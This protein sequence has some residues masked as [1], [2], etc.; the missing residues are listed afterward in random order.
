MA[1]GRP[2]IS[3]SRIATGDIAQHTF[4]VVRRGFDSDEVRSYLQSVARSL[5]A[6][7]AREEELRASLAEAEERA[8]HPVVDEATLTASLGQHSAQILRHA[9]EEAA[10][11]VV[12]AQEGAALLLRET[13]SQVDEL[14]ER[15]ETSAA[16]R[17]VEVELLVA[18]AE[19]EARVES[20][21]IVAEAI[22]AGEAIITR[23]K[24]E[25]RALL[26]QVQEA[27]RRVLAD[28][29]G[30][31]RGLGIQ[32]EQLR[33]ARDEMAASV[34]GVR[35]RVDGILAHLDRTD[36]DARAAAQGVA[37]QF[38]LGTA[39][40]PHDQDEAGEVRGEVPPT[41]PTPAVGGEAGDDGTAPSV[42][43]L[44][45]RI[46]AGTAAA[47]EA[48]AQEATVATEPPAVAPAKEAAAKEAPAKEGVVKEAPVAG[49]KVPDPVEAAPDIGT[50]AADDTTEEPAPVEDEVPPGPDDPLIARRDELVT[51]ISSRLSRT[52]KRTLGDD[53]NRLLDRLRNAPA[54]EL[55]DL[56]GSEDEHIGAFAAAARSHLDEAFAAGTIF[57]G[58]GAATIP[59]GNAVE[60]ASTALARTVVTTLRRQVDEG[61]GDPADRIGAA[62]RE[63]RG[64]RVE[65]LVGDQTTQAFS[66]GVA[67]ASAD[68]K[69]RWVLTTASGCSD[70]E[71][72]A[73]AGA[74]SGSEAFPTGHA[75]PPA[76]SGCRCLIAPA[77][78]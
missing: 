39:E 74:V 22:A 61:S 26:D 46:R 37:D 19:Q 77:T 6:L 64:E 48:A 66:A 59:R 36:E 10:R 49:A 62:F 17:V 25:G 72:N 4:A 21:R 20:E 28:L 34:H 73:L 56:M 12:Q 67:A 52:I 41:G 71:D 43:E 58:A 50:Q 54:A 76:H 75:H 14:Q 31:R 2:P 27:R 65:R 40:L 3:S 1:E 8:A 32:I 29:A 5:E 57:V 42:D 30:R 47:Q 7:E 23:A 9:H 68:G 78:D 35:D 13:Q 33:A 38:R 70:C 53:Q 51:P 15:T 69:V 16:E 24:D 11:I 18:N 63:W 45:A 60:Q 55:D 44:F